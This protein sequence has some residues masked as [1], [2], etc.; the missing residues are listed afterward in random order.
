[1]GWQSFPPCRIPCGANQPGVWSPWHLPGSL[2]PLQASLERIGSLTHLW[3][4]V[5]IPFWFFFPNREI[6]SASWVKFITR[7]LATVPRSPGA[8]HHYFLSCSSNS[9]L[10]RNDPGSLKPKSHWLLSITCGIKSILWLSHQTLSVSP[11]QIWKMSSLVLLFCRSKN[12][13]RSRLV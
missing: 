2:L 1:M 12:Q 5:F 6:P 7:I 3:G 9:L 11:W 10:S 13:M 4:F 8:L